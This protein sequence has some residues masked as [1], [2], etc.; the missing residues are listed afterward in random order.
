[1]PGSKLLPTYLVRRFSAW[2]TVSYER[3]RAWYRR[4]AEEGQHPRAMIITCC[5]SRIDVGTVFGA[6]PG[7]FFIHRNIASLVPP[8]EPD[9]DRHGTSAAI[10]YAVKALH[11]AHV[12]VLGHSR[13]GGVSGCHDMCMGEA[14]ELEAETSFVGRWMDIL[15]PAF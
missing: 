10:E 5:D 6:E 8:F 13:C 12:L 14:P 7:E 3:N 2:K 9:G 4:L 1:M 11:V 15:R